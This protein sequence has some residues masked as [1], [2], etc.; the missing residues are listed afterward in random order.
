MSNVWKF[1]LAGFAL[2][3]GGMG[4]SHAASISPTS[5]TTTIGVGETVT[6]DKTVT[7]DEGDTASKV[8]FYFLSDNTGSMGTVIGN[9]KSVAGSLLSALNSA[10][11]DAAF[12]VG[13][14]FG[15]PSEYYSGG[16][17]YAYD[18]L[19]S[20]TTNTSDVTTGI[21]SWIASGGGDGPEANFYALQQAATEGGATDGIG[22]A[23]TGV[24]SGE[25]TGWRDGAAKVVLWFG[26]Y[27]SHTETVDQAEA[28]AALNAA[29]VTVIGLNSRSVN[30][31]IDDFGQA[32]AVTGATGGALVNNFA[33]VATSDI[34]DTITAAV[35]AGL[36]TVDISL[37]A[38]PSL[39][40]IDVS[41]AC[42]D[43]AGCIDVAPGESRTL[44]MTV[45]G[46]AAGDYSYDTVL[47]GFPDVKEADRI[48]VGDGGVTV[49]EP[50]ILALMG[51]GLLAFG[52]VRRRRVS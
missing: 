50:S 2:L 10:Y 39:S 32:T 4:V 20:V 8:D 19:Q 29:G 52:W 40:G 38:D 37:F 12:G 41:Y 15:D 23:D 14:Y 22:S 16:P 46:L 31:G 25:A 36:G 1:W 33:S 47:A 7:I 17:D 13:R 49:P 24:G 28:I 18:V 51:G 5:Y 44:S 26:D 9:V 35:A 43:A 45:T 27:G 3:V 48:I 42:T 11:A 30:D 34:V 21:N 6:V